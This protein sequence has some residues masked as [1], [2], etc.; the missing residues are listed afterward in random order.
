MGKWSDKSLSLMTS[1]S[2]DPVSGKRGGET[3]VRAGNSGFRITH[4]H[5]ECVRMGV[6]CI[7]RE[8]YIKELAYMIMEA[9][10]SKIWKVSW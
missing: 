8:I 2:K 4:T 1:S 10:K 7:N 5:C 9:G 6:F 3:G